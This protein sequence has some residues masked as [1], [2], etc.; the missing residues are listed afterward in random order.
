M[1]PYNL[2]NAYF[3]SATYISN[4]PALYYDKLKKEVFK[5]VFFIIFY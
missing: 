5:W 2:E 1:E 3:H 4:M